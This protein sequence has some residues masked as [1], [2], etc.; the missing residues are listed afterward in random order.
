MKFPY[1]DPIDPQVIAESCPTQLDVR[2]G[3]YGSIATKASEDFLRQWKAIGGNFEGG[4]ESAKGSLITLGLPECKPER[5]EV[6]T[7]L[8]EFLFVVDDTFSSRKLEESEEAFLS[9]NSTI[10]ASDSHHLKTREKQ[11]YAQIFVELL[12]IDPK[13]GGMI[14]EVLDEYRS[15]IGT[16][17]AD[18]IQT[19]DEWLQYRWEDAACHVYMP[20]IVYG[21]E[22]DLTMADVKA[23]QHI[24]WPGMVATALTNDIYSFDREASLELQTGGNINNAVWRM[25]TEFDITA[26]E[27][28][29]KVLQDKIRPLEKQFLE[30][31]KAF[32]S[33]NEPS[34]LTYF[35]ELVGLMVSGNWYWGGSSIRYLNWRENVLRFGDVNAEDLEF[36]FVDEKKGK[37]SDYLKLAS[38]RVKAP[39]KYELS[40]S[41]SHV[42]NNVPN[43]GKDLSKAP[44]TEINADGHGFEANRSIPQAEPDASNVGETVPETLSK[45]ILLGPIEYIKGLPSKNVRGILIEALASWFTIPE[46]SLNRIESIVS[47]LH[48]ASL[49][50]DDVEDQSPLRRGKPSAHRIFGVSQ[51]INSANYLYVTAVD[52]LLHLNA[53]TSQE[54]FLDEMNNLHIGQSYDIHWARRSSFPSVAEY[55]QMIQF[56]TGGLFCMLGRLIYAQAQEPRKIGIDDL[57]SFLTLMGQ[58]FQI[59]DD[60]INLTSKTFQ[61]QKGYAEDLDEGKLSF[62]LIHLLSHSPDRLLIE[63]ILHERSKNGKMSFEAKELILEKMN[64]TKSLEFTKETLASLESQTRSAL[65]KL[66]KQSGTSNFMLQYLIERLCV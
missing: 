46:E 37:C 61:E 15:C 40:N 13:R 32:L 5:I 65:S 24:T 28:K 59:R 8:T 60:Y 50:L 63:N 21:S 23:V 54:A 2:L 35:V 22:L 26:Y 57:I 25:M 48:H 45:E 52:E 3:K 58:Y 11:I 53:S 64:Q 1:S 51:T 17:K 62:P 56:K 34:D 16:R 66:E 31:K 7:K 44:K 18:E 6:L 33:E 55:M 9:K 14:I 30:K 39:E 49:L 47:S 29:E 19:W 20:F 41:G 27:A 4:C 36:Y 10:A 42:D 43:H 12:K 38:M